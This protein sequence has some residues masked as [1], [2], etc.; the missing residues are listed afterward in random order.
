MHTTSKCQGR[1][2]GTTTFRNAFVYTKTRLRIPKEETHGPINHAGQELGNAYPG[3]YHS[4]C[5]K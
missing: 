5:L 2:F 1:G 3:K 4:G